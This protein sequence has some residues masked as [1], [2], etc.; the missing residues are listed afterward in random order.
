MKQRVEYLCK[1]MGIFS[2]I[3]LVMTGCGRREVTLDLTAEERFQRGMRL[4]DEGN[5]VRAIDELRIITRQ[6]SGSDF[7][8][9]AQFYMGMSYFN[10]GE[11]ILATNEFEIL[12]NTMSAS[13]LVP[14]AQ[15]KLALSYYNLSPRY[16]LDQEFTHKAIDELQAF[17]DFFPIHERVT[18]AEEKIRELNEKLARKEYENARL[19]MRMRYYRAATRIF[20]T[21]ID[22]YHDT[23]YAELA[24]IGKAE[25]LI[26]RNL[27]DEAN[28]TIQR[29]LHQFPNSNQRSR[30]RTLER[31]IA[32][33]LGDDNGPADNGPATGQTRTER[34]QNQEQF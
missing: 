26:E 31:R 19:Y 33:E 10:R 20:Q 17:V 2:L 7:A 9:D 25:A 14:E 12:I 24:H 13:P 32:S 11:Y 34:P 27:F 5:Y 6:F 29:F 16:D 23:P 22:R 3:L 8:D 28:E 18:E 1:A 15:Y 4:Y 30:A 21:V